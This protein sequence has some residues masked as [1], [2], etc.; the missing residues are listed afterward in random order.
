MDDSI[1]ED[2][3]EEIIEEEKSED[4][5]IDTNDELTEEE[6]IEEII[7]EEDLDYE[8]DPDNYYHSWDMNY[9]DDDEFGNEIEDE[10]RKLQLED[11]LWQEDDML[12]EIRDERE[13]DEFEGKIGT[14]ENM[15]SSNVR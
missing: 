5:F 3:I 6:L 1:L 7:E 14:T 11:E 4:L 10:L 15:M 8:D 9:E 12:Q 13:Q 2:E